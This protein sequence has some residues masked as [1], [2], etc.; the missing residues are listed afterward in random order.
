MINKVLKE[1]GKAVKKDLRKRMK[2]GE[3]SHLPVNFF[4]TD[5]RGNEIKIE[6]QKIFITDNL[7]GETTMHYQFRTTNYKPL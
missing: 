7:T 4:V 2:K 1:F 5:S 6:E 3:I